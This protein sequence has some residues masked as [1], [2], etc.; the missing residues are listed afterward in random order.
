[1]HVFVRVQ[2]GHPIMHVRLIPSFAGSCMLFGEQMVGCL[3]SL[4]ESVQQPGTS[5][6]VSPCYTVHIFWLRQSQKMRLGGCDMGCVPVLFSSLQTTI[7]SLW[8]IHLP[9][10]FKLLCI[11]VDVYATTASRLFPNELLIVYLLEQNEKLLL[12]P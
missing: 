9:K 12:Q 6:K 11:R 3:A 2:A 7:R 1:M 10:Q 5:L 8:S 4:F